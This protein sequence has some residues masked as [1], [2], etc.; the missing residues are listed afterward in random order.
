[1]TATRYAGPRQQPE[2]PTRL[3]LAAIETAK[4]HREGLREN[5][6]YRD[7]GLSAAT[8]AASA[9]STRAR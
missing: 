8:A 9:P 4:F 6:E 2:S 7:L 3:N 1:M 5:F